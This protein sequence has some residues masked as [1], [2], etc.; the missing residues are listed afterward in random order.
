MSRVILSIILGIFISGCNYKNNINENHHLLLNSKKIN[1]YD[2]CSDFSYISKIKNEKYGDLFFEYISLDSSCSWNG[3][4]RGYFEYL[5]KTTLKLK[6]FKTIDRIDIENYEFSTY[7]INDEYYINI[8]YKYSTFEDLFIIDY[9]G[10]YFTKLIKEFDE[11]YENKYLNKKR[12]SSN[13]SNSLVKMNFINSY[14]SRQRESFF[15]E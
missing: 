1:T 12:F 7:L 11:A 3:L 14:F 9:D 15:D 8:I 2:S 5:F 4:S 10:K 13:Y 6:S